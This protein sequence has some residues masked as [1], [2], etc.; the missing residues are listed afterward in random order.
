M[1]QRQQLIALILLLL[2]G[3]GIAFFVINNKKKKKKTG[4]LKT[5]I[6]AVSSSIDEKSEK[7]GIKPEDMRESIQE[8]L[9]KIVCAYG[10]PPCISDQYVIDEKGCC[11]QK[12]PQ[13]LSKTEQGLL[14]ANKLGQELAL[15]LVIDELLEQG[16]KLAGKLGAKLAGKLAAKKIT[17]TAAKLAAKG[18]A[19]LG[20][21]MGKIGKAMSSGPF[22]VFEVASAL[23]DVFDPA[24]Y[25]SYK[26]NDQN[27]K[28]QKIYAVAMEK[29]CIEAGIPY[30]LLVPTSYIFPSIA[31]S[32][33]SSLAAEFMGK[34][35]EK[36]GDE[37]PDVLGNILIAAFD[38]NVEASDADT[39]VFSD[40]LTKVMNDDPKKRDDILYKFFQDNAPA[41]KLKYLQRYPT[42]STKIVQGVSL[43]EEGVKYYNLLNRDKFIKQAD[44]QPLVALYTNKYF[45]LNQANPGSSDSPNTVIKTLM[46]TDGRAVT[47]PLAFPFGGVYANCEGTLV[48][49]VL[50][51]IPKPTTLPYQFGVRFNN[52]TG[53]CDMTSRWCTRMGQQFDSSGYTNCKTNDV[54]K[55][56]EYILGTTVTRGTVQLTDTLG[57]SYFNSWG[58]SPSCP[59]G[60]ENK[61]G[62]C[63]DKCRSGY[64]SSALECEGSCPSGS[65]DTGL[66]CLQGT[67]S[68]LPDQQAKGWDKL[69]FWEKK[70]WCSDDCR[71]GYSEKLKVG[72][73]H[74]CVKSCMPGFT[75]RSNAAGTAFCDKGRPRYSRAFEGTI[76]NKCKDGETLEGVLCY[77]KCPKGYYNVLSDCFPC[78][79]LAV[80]KKDKAACRE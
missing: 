71:S 51:G 14:I 42:L 53:T 36:L 62:L 75:R 44:D 77:P 10:K 9:D 35:M 61:A 48:G 21:A 78:T 58:R 31:E 70:V 49:E 69:K 3:V 24:G 11:A 17:G 39:D 45:A 12:T 43:S 40:M 37:N 20:L 47:A 32:A 73:T 72:C 19:K 76:P 33:N 13:K 6:K 5:D 28:L 59:T 66:T 23:L 54:Q 18:A 56:F 27:I 22:M 52:R 34:A 2:V 57:G 7:L 30:P 79:G 65:T 64:R 80:G 29:N 4:D 38:D 55:A 74:T 25:T 8:E 1:K 67:S 46:G 50:P 15:S 16:L 60:T 26:S 41:D 68:Y 63:Y